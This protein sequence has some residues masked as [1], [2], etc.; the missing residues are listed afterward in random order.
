MS[1]R[2]G[3]THELRPFAAPLTGPWGSTAHRQVGETRATRRTTGGV[4]SGVSVDARSPTGPR[5]FVDVEIV[6]AV[7]SINRAVGVPATRSRR[8]STV[9]RSRR[10]RRTR[11]GDSRAGARAAG[12]PRMTGSPTR[13]G[14]RRLQTRRGGLGSVSPKPAG[15]SWRSSATG[16]V[17]DPSRISK[18][19]AHLAPHHLLAPCDAGGCRAVRSRSGGARSPVDDTAL[20]A[21]VTGG[22]GP[23]DPHSRA[24]G[25][26]ARG[27]PKTVD[28]PPKSPGFGDIL[29]TGLSEF[30]NPS[31]FKHLSHGGAGSRKRMA[32]RRFLSVLVSLCHPNRRL[33]ARTGKLEKLARGFVAVCVSRTVA[34]S[35]QSSSLRSP[36][37]T[38]VASTWHTLVW[39]CSWPHRVRRRSKRRGS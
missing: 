13:G 17:A 5:L 14:A 39:S 8:P 3:F 25:A 31:D 2:S 7:H 4:T 6:P 21:P 10:T 19:P 23:C 26:L 15:T 32:R 16:F 37:W 34:N 9:S 1:C 18:E 33:W 27:H 35:L 20:H 38:A 11:P 12:A 28:P 30:K 29:E 22:A 36:S 24:A